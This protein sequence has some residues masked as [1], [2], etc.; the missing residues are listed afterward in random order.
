M[1]RQQAFEWRGRRWVLSAWAPAGLSE[2]G[3]CA[4]TWCL[5]LWPGRNNL[6]R[7]ERRALC[8][9]L[10]ETLIFA[11]Q[12]EEYPETWAEKLVPGHLVSREVRPDYWCSVQKESCRVCHIEIPLSVTWITVMASSTSN[13]IVWHPRSTLIDSSLLLLS[14]SGTADLPKHSTIYRVLDTCKVLFFFL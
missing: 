10:W 1:K 14:T 8:S 12:A 9:E 2:R 7:E 6:H 4:Y 13:S 11:E 5:G 3:M